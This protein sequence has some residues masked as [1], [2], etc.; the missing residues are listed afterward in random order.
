MYIYDRVEKSTF[1]DPSILTVYDMCINKV[2]VAQNIEGSI[3]ILYN[4]IR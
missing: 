3:S 2:T 1:L 4:V